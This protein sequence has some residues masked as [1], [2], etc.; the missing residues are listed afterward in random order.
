MPK[1]LSTK[2][3]RK[4]LVSTVPVIV[5]AALAVRGAYVLLTAGGAM[6]LGPIDVLAE[7]AAIMVGAAIIG[8]IVVFGLIR[9]IGRWINRGTDN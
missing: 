4:L 6:P 3:S 8:A 9:P 5:L 2:K 7:I 1:V